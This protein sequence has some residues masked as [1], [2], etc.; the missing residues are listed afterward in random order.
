MS[1][2]GALDKRGECGRS[3]STRFSGCE[4][5][6]VERAAARRGMNAAEFTRHAALGIESGRCAADRSAFSSRY[7]DMIER[8]FP[9][10]PYPGDAETQ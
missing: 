6:A 4:R 3:R 8:I 1:Q 9:R 2:T 7:V 10:H 5:E